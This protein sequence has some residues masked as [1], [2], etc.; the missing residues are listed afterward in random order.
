MTDR[1]NLDPGIQIEYVNTKQ[2]IEDVLTQVSF[3]REGW[4]QFTHLFNLTTPHLHSNNNVAVLF[5]NLWKVAARETSVE[6]H[7]RRHLTEMARS[8]CDP[9]SPY[10]RQSPLII[11]EDETSQ[12]WLDNKT[13][14]DAGCPCPVD[15]ATRLALQDRLL[16]VRTPSLRLLSSRLQ[17]LPAT[18]SQRSLAAIPHR[19][20]HK[21]ASV[22]Q[23]KPI[24]AF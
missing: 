18:T 8:V 11:S 24:G 3:S 22:F 16:A 20:G 21:S 1:I 10:L 2:R 4:S 13:E 5:F 14:F 17:T 9:T 7:R 12:N 23:H 15:S 19:C 6:L